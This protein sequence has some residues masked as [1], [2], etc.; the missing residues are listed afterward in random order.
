[1]MKLWHTLCYICHRTIEHNNYTTVCTSHDDIKGPAEGPFLCF[2]YILTAG[3]PFFALRKLKYLINY[4]RSKRA[5]MLNN[6]HFL[7]LNNY[8][9][10]VL[11][12]IFRYK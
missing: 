11:Y 3:H 2:L 5:T 12:A 6:F 8:D 9:F 1:M 7:A 4:L 10:K